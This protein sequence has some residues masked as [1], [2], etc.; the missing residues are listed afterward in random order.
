M[1]LSVETFTEVGIDKLVKVLSLFGRRLT[2]MKASSIPLE[3]RKNT[4]IECIMKHYTSLPDDKKKE[5]ESKIEELVSKKREVKMV[6]NDL[7]QFKVGMEVNIWDNH[8]LKL[9]IIKK[10]NK[11]SLTIGLYDFDLTEKG[12]LKREEALR[13]QTHGTIE[14]KWNKSKERTT[15]K[16]VRDIKII[17]LPTYTRDFEYGEYRV[18]YG[19]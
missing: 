4:I 8:I 13:N 5:Y 12:K 1:S 18:D 9:A 15:T 3:T 10:I 6:E 2:N 11:N 14:I 19:A 17:S 7:T 16:V